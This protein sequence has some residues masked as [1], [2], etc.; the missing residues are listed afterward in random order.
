MLDVCMEYAEAYDILFNG[1]GLELYQFPAR[2][3]YLE[4]FD[5]ASDACG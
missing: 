5:I 1:V 3:L 2:I 4:L